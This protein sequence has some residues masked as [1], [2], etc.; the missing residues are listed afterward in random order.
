MSR[1][2]NRTRRRSRAV[3]LSPADRADAARVTV[4]CDDSLARLNG[5]LAGKVARVTRSENGICIIWHREP[6]AGDRATADAIIAGS[7]AW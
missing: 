4:S 2:S 1:P 7:H 5:A 6:T 3:A